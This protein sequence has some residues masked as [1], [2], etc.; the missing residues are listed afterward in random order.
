MV[1]QPKGDHRSAVVYCWPST[2]LVRPSQVHTRELANRR[3]SLAIALWFFLRFRFLLI[4][5]DLRKILDQSP[6][7]PRHR[8][9][10]A[11]FLNAA[12]IHQL[13]NTSDSAKRVCLVVAK[14]SVEC[15]FTIGDAR[16]DH[17][18]HVLFDNA[19]RMAMQRL[20]AATIFP[21]PFFKLMP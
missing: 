15:R 6:R 9:S 13:K 1:I 21:K 4:A 18:V 12:L 3:W 17:S 14:Q 11:P 8:L 19:D 16:T 2:W 5:W 7:S 10:V 20:L